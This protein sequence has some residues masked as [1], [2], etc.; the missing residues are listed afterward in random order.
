MAWIIKGKIAAYDYQPKRAA[1]KKRKRAVACPV[2]VTP[3]K[4]RPLRRPVIRLGQPAPAD[5]PK[6]SAIVEPKQKPP[7]SIF[8][9]MREVPEEE[10]QPR[11]DAADALWHE[12]VR[13]ASEHD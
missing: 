7:P 5:Q 8:A 13:R 11:G 3:A 12:L 4:L 6:R 10:L 9:P 1:R 2:I